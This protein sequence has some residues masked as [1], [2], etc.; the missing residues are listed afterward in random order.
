[1]E[2]WLGSGR[3]LALGTW[4][5]S[6]YQWWWITVD[7]GIATWQWSCDWV[8]SSAFFTAYSGI[9]RHHLSSH[10]WCQRRTLTMIHGWLL[11]VMTCDGFPALLPISSLHHRSLQRMSFSGSMIINS[12]ELD[13]S[14][15]PLEEPFK[16]IMLSSRLSPCIVIFFRHVLRWGSDL[17]RYSMR[18]MVCRS[19][20]LANIVT[21][22][23]LQL[24][25]C[26]VT[27]GRKHGQISQERRFVYSNTCLGCN[28]CF[29]TAQRLQQHLKATR[30]Q[31]N[32]CYHWIAQHHE[33]LDGPM[34]VQA[35]RDL[36]RFQRLPTC[37]VSGPQHENILPLWQQRQEKRLVDLRE[38]WRQHGFPL[39][40]DP[41][42]CQVVKGVL[43][44]TTG[45]MV[46]QDPA[47]YW[48]DGSVDSHVSGCCSDFRDE[49]VMWAFF[50]WGRSDMYPIL[51]GL[52]D[53]DVI[54]QV[55]LAFLEIAGAHPMWQ[56]LC[57]WDAV[58]Q[59]RAPPA[60]QVLQ[61][62][63]PK[64][65]SGRHEREGIP[66]YLDQQ[67]VL[68]QPWCGRA[69]LEKICPKGYTRCRRGRW[70]PYAVYPPSLLGRRRTGDC[71]LIFTKYGNSTSELRQSKWCSCP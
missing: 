19:S 22:C 44:Q 70:L 42:I 69:V 2:L 16:K 67:S 37:V 61:L 39:S 9:S 29:W 27:S 26:K 36:L 65:S 23:S 13:R 21:G 24:K 8:Q 35:D 60:E 46:C 18:T 20:I 59:W 7:A 32:G 62:Q 47:T 68:L 48:L 28:R 63:P 52:D 31:V 58:C 56:L 64:Q 54:E 33:P 38:Q 55:E 43:T 1:M 5:S 49:S 50:E 51:D 53:P 41:A 6:Q 71:D 11:F 57:D 10:S 25:R 17:H 40:L 15:G 66:Y 30:A 14:D 45:H 12:M 3:L 34:N 4:S